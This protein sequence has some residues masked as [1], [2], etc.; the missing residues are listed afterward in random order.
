MT[1]LDNGTATER[2][3]AYT[4]PVSGIA[5]DDN[6]KAATDLILADLA[7]LT[8]D[9]DLIAGKV[10]SLSKEDIKNVNLR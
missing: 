2:L 3:G 5:S 7:D 1:K 4:G 6:D 10:Y 8:G 9:G